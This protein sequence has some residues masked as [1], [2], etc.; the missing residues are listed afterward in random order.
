[1]ADNRRDPRIP[2]ETD[3]LLSHPAVGRLCLK[4]RDLSDG[5]VF[6]LTEPQP[7]LPPGAEVV[8]QVRDLADAP[9]VPA[10]VLRVDDEGLALA[11]VTED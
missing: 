3:I 11:F 4:S 6:L 9:E 10:R 1:M 2:V 5:G 8:L 7:S